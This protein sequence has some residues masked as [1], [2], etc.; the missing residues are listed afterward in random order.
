[1]PLALHYKEKNNFLCDLDI[2]Q[3]YAE[4]LLL[5]NLYTQHNYFCIY[6]IIPNSLKLGSAPLTNPF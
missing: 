6:L 5:L 3:I 1:M 2:P 4:F